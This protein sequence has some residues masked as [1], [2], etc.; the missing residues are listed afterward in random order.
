[1]DNRYDGYMRAAADVAREAGAFLKRFSD[2]HRLEVERKGS[3]FDFVTNADRESQALISRRLREAFPDH[4]FIGEEDG[5]SDGEITRRLRDGAEDWVWVCDPLDGTVNYIHHLG[6]YAV[7]VGLIHGGRSV[8]GAICLPETGEVFHA[9]RGQG[10]FVNGAP[11]RASGCDSLHRAMVAMDIPVNDLD[12]RRRFTKWLDGVSL[13]SAQLRVMGSACF[14]L[15]RVA[16]GDLE[17][18]ADLGVH[19]WD[20][21][22]GQVIV[23][24]AG[25]AMTN[26]FGRPF[27]YDM[28]GGAL[29]AAPGLAGAFQG[30][31]RP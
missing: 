17:A 5:L 6:V 14:A 21:A 10:A 26:L 1:M 16:R 18:Y 28:T 8:A 7:S 15:A 13:A 4:R 25:G 20:V 31:I 23:E 12:Q 30:I 11:I 9:A 27:N 19:A 24:E 22:A 29:A 3:D 2:G